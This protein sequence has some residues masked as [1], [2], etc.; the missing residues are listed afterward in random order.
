M[1][2]GVVDLP[3][4]KPTFPNWP[5]RSIERAV[6]TLDAAGMDLLAKMLAYEPAKRISARA[7]LSHPFFDS[8]D[9]SAL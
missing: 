2:P 9:K 1:W 3:D 6:P 4:Y 8:L 7:A 5:A